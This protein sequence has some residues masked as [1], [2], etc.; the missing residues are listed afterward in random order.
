MQFKFL[1]VC[2]VCYQETHRRAGIHTLKMVGGFQ[3]TLISFFLLEGNKDG[4]GEGG[5]Q[6]RGEGLTTVLAPPPLPFSPQ[7]D[8][9]P[10]RSLSSLSS[11]PLSPCLLEMLSSI[12]FQDTLFSTPASLAITSQST[13][14]DHPPL[15]SPP[16]IFLWILSSDLSFSQFNHFL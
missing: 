6:V 12:N 10:A 11:H 14:W 5:R 15:L 8:P 1:Y 4:R 13:L 7:P 3:V 16:T 9:T 2:R